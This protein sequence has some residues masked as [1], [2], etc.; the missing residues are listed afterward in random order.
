MTD[1]SR[2]A[3]GVLIAVL[4]VLGV[5]LTAC[6]GSEEESEPAASASATAA[7]GYPFDTSDVGDDLLATEVRTFQ[8]GN[9]DPFSWRFPQFYAG[10]ESDETSTTIEVDDVLYGLQ[11]GAA[12]ETS[13]RAKAEEFAGRLDPGD[14]EIHDVRLGGRDWVAAV[15]DSDSISH[16]VLYGSLPGGIV[17][18]GGFSAT[19]P[20][21]DVPPERIA[22]LHQMVLSIESG[23]PDGG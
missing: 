5:F 23:T 21:A 3:T 6:G 22:E 18:G 17:V 2:R 12:T 4:A 16:V 10:G 20:L 8:A 9:D 13:P 11:A 14:A 19:G 1:R 15:T 7:D